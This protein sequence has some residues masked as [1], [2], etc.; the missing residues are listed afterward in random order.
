MN[1]TTA[2]YTDT[3]IST[4]KEIAPTDPVDWQLLG[5]VNK[6]KEVY[7]FGNDSKIIGRAFEVV[8]ALYIKELAEKLGYS[9]HESTSQTVYP[10]FYLKRQDGKRIAI[11]VKST[12]RSFDRAGK[13]KY[14]KF[15]LGSFTSYLRDGKKNIDGNYEDYVGH[16][17]LAFLYS[18]TDRF[19]TQKVSVENIGDI[20]PAF[21]DVEVV[22]MEK[23]R[24]GGD[25]TGSGNTDNLATFEAK[26]LEPFSRGAGPFAFLGQDVFDHYWRNH[27]RNRDS[28][29]TKQSLFRNLPAYFTWLERTQNTVFDVKDLRAKYEEY[30]KW[31]ADEGLDI[32]VR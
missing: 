17:V 31:V 29:E 3:I 21:D 22:M 2:P 32:R 25:T 10:D 9:F 8:A 7:T 1:T 12:Y 11:D 16:Y 19:S 18:R 26:S 30:K 6:D 24:I 14:F 28:T 27:P 5:I 15:T 23:F 13:T 4:F 20:K